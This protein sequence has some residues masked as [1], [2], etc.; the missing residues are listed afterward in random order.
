MFDRL[1]EPSFFYSSNIGHPLPIRIHSR[2]Q[3]PLSF[4]SPS[5]FLLPSN[6]FKSMKPW[7][8]TGILYTYVLNS[9]IKLH[10]VFLIR[11]FTSRDNEAMKT[12]LFSYFHQILSYIA[13]LATSNL[14]R[15]RQSLFQEKKT[16]HVLFN[17]FDHNNIFASVEIRRRCRRIPSPFTFYEKKKKV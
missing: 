11:M 7:S 4:I 17:S 5:L 16:L 13:P 9:F 14:S 15:D 2:F 6:S 12:K 10:I 3:F 1:Q 8:I